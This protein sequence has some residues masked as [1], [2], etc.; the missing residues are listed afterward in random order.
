MASTVMTTGTIVGAK[1][2]VSDE[3]SMISPTN[4]PVVTM[5]G[6]KAA[7][8]IVFSWQQDVLDPPVQNAAN[9]GAQAPAASMNPTVMESNVQ[10]IFTKTV[11]VTGS[12]EAI[13]TYGR[14]SEF[15]YQLAKKGKEIKRDLEFALVGTRQVSSTS[16][17]RMMAG[18]QAQ[19]DPTMQNV[20]ATAIVLTE[21][22]ILAA[23][24]AAYNTGAEPSKFLVASGNATVIADFVGSAGRIRDLTDLKKIVNAVDV[25]VTPFGIELTV[26]IDRWLNPADAI[27]MDPSMWKMRPLRPWF[28]K[29]LPENGDYKASELI[30]EYSLEHSNTTADYLITGLKVE[31]TGGNT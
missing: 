18:V 25:Y 12:L 5:I 21:Q 10:Q 28:T 23:S 7:K 11:Q 24:Q 17:P 4:T 3:I 13:S 9:E 15:S 29:E 14:G 20:L 27:V 30:G 26:V 2:D 16:Q 6:S 31:T 22:M 8:E 1:L 19:I